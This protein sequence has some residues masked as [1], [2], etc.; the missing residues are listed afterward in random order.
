MPERTATPLLPRFPWHPAM[1]S[2]G[3]HLCWTSYEAV[4]RGQGAGQPGSGLHSEGRHQAPPSAFYAL[5][6]P[7]SRMCHILFGHW[8][9]E[10]SAGTASPKRIPMPPAAGTSAACPSTP[11]GPASCSSIS[12]DPYAPASGP[13]QAGAE[14]ASGVITTAESG[15]SPPCLVP[16]ESK[17]STSSQS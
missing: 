9:Q 14:E 6:S 11:K 16:T 10:P 5:L 7:P 2:V 15:S 4:M 3:D 17:G 12:S 13:L 8:V 1:L